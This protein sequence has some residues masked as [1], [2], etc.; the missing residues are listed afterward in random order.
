MKIL[1]AI[2]WI[3]CIVN[4]QILNT[5]ER[6]RVLP[7]GWGWPRVSYEKISVAII[8]V[9]CIIYLRTHNPIESIEGWERPRVCCVKNQ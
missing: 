8:R 9:F 2:I 1:I 6:E 5:R 4:V 3:F 7:N